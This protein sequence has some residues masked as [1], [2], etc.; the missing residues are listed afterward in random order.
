VGHGKAA[1]RGRQPQARNPPGWR[2]Q[3]VEREDVE[4]D[5]HQPRHQQDEVAQERD[6]IDQRLALSLVGDEAALAHLEA[7]RAE[8]RHRHPRPDHHGEQEAEQ[9]EA[10]GPQPGSAWREAR[11]D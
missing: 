10:L 6:H 4:R 5:E 11:R 8:D 7:R 3:Q 9:N 1:E 2:R